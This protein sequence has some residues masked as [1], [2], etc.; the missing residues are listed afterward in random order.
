MKS[1]IRE[2]SN[3]TPQRER[4]AP[5]RILDL[6]SVNVYVT[7]L[8]GFAAMD[9]RLRLECASLLA[10]IEASPFPRLLTIFWVHLYGESYLNLVTD[11]PTWDS[12]I[13]LLYEVFYPASYKLMFGKRCG[14]PLTQ[15]ERK[16]EKLL[17]SW[18]LYYHQKCSEKLAA[19]QKVLPAAL[20]RNLEQLRKE[21]GMSYVELAD[22]T[23]LTT[24]QIHRHMTGKKAYPSTLNAYAKAFTISLERKITA[25]DLLAP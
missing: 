7:G 20:A 2:Q 8:A 6:A 18:I 15:D 16:L 10:Q 4:P 3:P 13:I 11:Q 25:S 14:M 22:K 1:K 23:G 19:C 21:C 5:Q 17:H 24:R 12:F 9:A